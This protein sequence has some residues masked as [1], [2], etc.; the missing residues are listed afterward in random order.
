MTLVQ[1]RRRTGARPDWCARHEK[2]TGQTDQGRRVLDA[3][4]IQA[5]GPRFERLPR[6]DREREEVESAGALC[7][8]WVMA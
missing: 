8:V 7:S 4:L 2:P 1:I 3:Y 6:I 5:L